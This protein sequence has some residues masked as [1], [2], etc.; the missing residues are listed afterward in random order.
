MVL[1]IGII[2]LVSV[3]PSAMSSFYGNTATG[4]PGN[5]SM[6]TFNPGAASGYNDTATI[7][8]YRLLPFIGVLAAFLL[9]AL[10]VMKI[11]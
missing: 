2:I 11:L 3:L 6:F 7:A 8:I 9:I 1:V 5:Q 10:P 4:T